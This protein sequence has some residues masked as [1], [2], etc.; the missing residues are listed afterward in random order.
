[1][2]LA[3]RR[4]LQNLVQARSTIRVSQA[5]ANSIG[6]S[7]SLKIHRDALARRTDYQF[8][9]KAGGHCSERLQLLLLSS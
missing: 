2:L 3:S 8:M 5:C 6:S 9:R 1:M 7:E 4:V